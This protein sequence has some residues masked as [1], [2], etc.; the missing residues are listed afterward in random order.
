MSRFCWGSRLETQQVWC[1]SSISKLWTCHCTCR[2]ISPMLAF[3]TWAEISTTASSHIVSHVWC[4]GAT[5]TLKDEGVWSLA[6]TSRFLIDQIRRIL[7]PPNTLWPCRDS[8]SARVGHESCQ[9]YQFCNLQG[10]RLVYVVGFLTHLLE[11]SGA[12]LWHSH[13]NIIKW[14]TC[15][16]CSPSWDIVWMLGFSRL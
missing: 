7:I 3:P 4:K 2:K 9:M 16:C 13:N 5:H 11:W 1:M 15:M 14:S 10:V 6:L 12:C 8:R